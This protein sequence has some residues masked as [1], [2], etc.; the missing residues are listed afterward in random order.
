MSLNYIDENGNLIQV[1]GN[2]GENLLD[3]TAI[4]THK[5]WSSDEISNRITHTYMCRNTV[6]ESP[7]ISDDKITSYYDGLTVNAMIVN[8]HYGNSFTI[9]L[10]LLTPKKV[11]CIKNG[12]VIL[13]SSYNIDRDKN[14]EGS[15][16]WYCQ[17]MTKLELLYDT[18]L[19]SNNGGWIILSNVIV[20]DSS[21]GSYHV[22]SNGFIEYS[23]TKVDTELGNKLS[24]SGGTMTGK[25]TMP[26]SQYGDNAPLDMNNSDIKGLNALLWR[27]HCEFGEGLSFPRS[28]GDTIDWLRVTD[29]NIK[30]GTNSTNERTVAFIDQV[31]RPNSYPSSQTYSDYIKIEIIYNSA[32]TTYNFILNSRAG[33]S[34]LL[35]FGTLDDGHPT[36]VT[37]IRFANMHSKIDAIKW[38]EV[39]GKLTLYVR[40]LAY[41]HST[42][43]NQIAGVMC[44]FN[45]TTSNA[46]EFNNAPNTVTIKTPT[47]T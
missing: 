16:N 42:L 25:I 41:S 22:Y 9:G 4:T 44:S 45:I 32:I 20:I 37:A 24:T 35:S 26:Q 1:A 33:E 38:S 36:N 43:I 23:K 30:F 28:S 40:R 14:N 31:F 6:T 47:L 13:M 17:E 12:D 15:Q 10:N 19:D 21:D 18:T 2:A 46:T 3:D 29:G 11:Y 27:D 34:I 39:W 5:T 7:V 8:G